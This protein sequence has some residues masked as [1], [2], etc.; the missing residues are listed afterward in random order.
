MIDPILNRLAKHSAAEADRAQQIRWQTAQAIAAKARD[1][2]DDDAV[3][4]ALTVLGLSERH[5]QEDVDL[6][7]QH[8]E[9]RRLAD[10]TPVEALTNEVREIAAAAEARHHAAVQELAAA[11]RD[12]A[13]AR[14]AGLRVRAAHEA[15]MAARRDAQQLELQLVER[16]CPE[17]IAEQRQRELDAEEER[18]RDQQQWIQEAALAP[19]QEADAALADGA[20]ALAEDH[21]ADAAPASAA[22]EC[23]PWPSSRDERLMRAAAAMGGPE[24]LGHDSYDVLSQ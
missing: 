17:A 8:A 11:D 2:H 6:L 23:R 18:L 20:P 19:A 24:P 15:L 21:E 1:P 12:L 16:G 9:R 7:S 13:A 10:P 14:D 4:S 22:P 3:R 5:L